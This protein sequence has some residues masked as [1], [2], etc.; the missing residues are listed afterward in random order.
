MCLC[1][2]LAWLQGEKRFA[3]EM[4]KLVGRQMD[5]VKNVMTSKGLQAAEREEK[6]AQVS[7]GV[8]GGAM[9]E[10]LGAGGGAM[11]VGEGREGG[12]PTSQCQPGG[13]GLGV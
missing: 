6:I 10:G 9:D 1:L 5:E 3:E 12:R 2:C 11:G 7:D 4:D 13:R 8:G